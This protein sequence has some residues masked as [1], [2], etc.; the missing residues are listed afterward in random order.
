MTIKT[1]CGHVHVSDNR[2]GLSYVSTSWLLV[3]AMLH[4]DVSDERTE[5]FH[6]ESDSRECL[7]ERY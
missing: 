4:N 2:E 3:D 5:F 6:D 1:I 7:C